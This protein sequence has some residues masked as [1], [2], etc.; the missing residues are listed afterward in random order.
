MKTAALFF[1]VSTAVMPLGLAEVPPDFIESVSEA[2][3]I[4]PERSAVIRQQAKKLVEDEVELF[5]SFEVGSMLS[6]VFYEL[7]LATISEDISA[8]SSDE[9]LVRADFKDESGKIY[10]VDLFL[11]QFEEDD[12]EI[13]D[14][15]LVEDPNLPAEET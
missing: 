11:L 15:V 9:Y 2:A 10:K 5:G 12:Y 7:L 6:G 1:L 8:L 3:S 4:S 13:V 14:A